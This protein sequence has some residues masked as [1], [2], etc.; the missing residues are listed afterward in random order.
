MKHLNLFTNS[1]TISMA[2]KSDYE[3]QIAKHKAKLKRH[4]TKLAK[5]PIVTVIGVTGA[6]GGGSGREHPKLS[7]VCVKFLSWRI[8]G[9]PIQP[10]ELTLNKYVPFKQR[11][12]FEETFQPYSVYRFRARV[13]VNSEL[14]RPDGLLIGKVE[15]CASD[16]ELNA[17]VEKSQ[18]PVIVKDSTFGKLTLDRRHNWYEAKTKWSG[19]KINL[20]IRDDDDQ[21]QNNLAVAHELWKKQASW[22][23]RV[24]DY[25]VKQMLELKNDDWLDDD[26][27]E[28]SPTQFK[29]LMKLTTIQ[30]DSDKRIIFFF[31]DGKMFGG[32]S[33]LIHC[34]LAAGPFQDEL[35]G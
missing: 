6:D 29:K 8:E 7:G 11:D 10:T 32:H 33:I 1:Q 30:V 12:L 20:T 35:F 31:E 2:K 28:L 4:D 3:V 16:K 18:L 27:K 13:V 26:E 15:P 22:D 23:K 34:S 9:E 24:R 14:G 17:V 25:A 5:A 21:F 19:Q